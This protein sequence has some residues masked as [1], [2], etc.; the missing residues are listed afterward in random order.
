KTNHDTSAIVLKTISQLVLAA[1]SA[2][3]IFKKK[4]KN[5]RILNDSLTKLS[6]DPKKRSS[7]RKKREATP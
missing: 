7:F 5:S 2:A 4:E 1:M 6:G 3:F